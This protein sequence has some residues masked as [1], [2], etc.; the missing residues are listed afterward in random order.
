MSSKSFYHHQSR[1]QPKNFYHGR[2]T[3]STANRSA[4]PALGVQ[5]SLLFD[6]NDSR[7]AA[8]LVVAPAPAPVP[9]F[10]PLPPDQIFFTPCTSCG[11]R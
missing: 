5:H 3:A 10:A 1:N 9:T 11:K 2:N 6:N 4:S 8:P 7:S